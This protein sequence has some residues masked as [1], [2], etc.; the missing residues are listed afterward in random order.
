MNTKKNSG[1]FRISGETII[2]G[3]SRIVPGFAETYQTYEKTFTLRQRNKKRHAE[4]R[5]KHCKD[6]ASL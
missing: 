4:I 2:A 6:S 1:S 5:T 3:A